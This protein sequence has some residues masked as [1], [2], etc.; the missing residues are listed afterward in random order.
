M[1]NHFGRSFNNIENEHLLTTLDTLESQGCVYCKLYNAQEDVAHLYRL[2]FK[3]DEIFRFVEA[4]Y[5][6]EEF[7]GFR[8]QDYS[9]EDALEEISSAKIQT[10]VEEYNNWAEEEGHED[11][12][13][14][15]AAFYGRDLE[16]L[17]TTHHPDRQEKIPRKIWTE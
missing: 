9:P 7:R 15:P 4:M 6:Y 5:A 1:P 14:C 3:P 8:R 11:L 16:A 13:Y 10:R 2:S 12:L 17:L